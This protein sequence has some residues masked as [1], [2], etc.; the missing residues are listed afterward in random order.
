[1]HCG[2]LRGVDS[3]HAAPSF[4]THMGGRQ[5]HTLRRCTNSESMQRTTPVHQLRDPPHVTSVTTT[6]KMRLAERRSAW[7][8]DVASLSS[9][10]ARSRPRS[11]GSV[12][13][14]AWPSSPMASVNARLRRRRS[15]AGAVRASWCAHHSRGLQVPSL[16]LFLAVRCRA[17]HRLARRRF[18]GP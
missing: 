10:T 4:I 16:V 2:G 13:R 18:L 3:A 11:A 7:C 8:I 1:M 14:D 12:T 17:R 15:H 5:R 9:S 6:R